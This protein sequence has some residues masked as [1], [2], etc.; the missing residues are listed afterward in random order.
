MRENNN[1][2]MYCEDDSSRELSLGILS[3]SLREQ[4]GSSDQ[5]VLRS[6]DR[7]LCV[8]VELLR[9][10]G[11]RWASVQVIPGCPW[12]PGSRGRGLK[13]TA[14]PPWAEWRWGAV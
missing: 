4:R 11:T 9:I 6:C 8:I 12:R 1:G 5:A 14:D 3:C 7:P 2:V 13:V 10:Y